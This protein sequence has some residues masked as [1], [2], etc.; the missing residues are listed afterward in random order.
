VSFPKGRT[1]IMA[2]Q[3]HT[4]ARRTSSEQTNMPSWHHTHTH[5]HT[6]TRA[7]DLIRA[8]KD[9]LGQAHKA[10]ALAL[11]QLCLV[12]HGLDRRHV[13]FGIACAASERVH[14]GKWE[15]LEDPHMWHSQQPRHTH[16]HT[17]THRHTD[18]HPHHKSRTGDGDAE[19]VAVLGTDVL[20]KIA[21]A[22]EAALYGL[23]L[24]A[25]GRV[26]GRVSE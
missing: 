7:A 20:D 16:T 6:H 21:G 24:L 2:S 5:T 9:A 8:D 10:P 19:V 23:P 15:S 11:C 13:T 25:H 22:G 1:S 4:Y 17:D 12:C 14:V 18:T 3:T 26:C